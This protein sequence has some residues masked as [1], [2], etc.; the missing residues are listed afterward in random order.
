MIP[1]WLIIGSITFLVAILINR[2]S[3]SD[4]RWFMRLRRPQWL[5]F[6]WAIPFI[7]T[8][9]FIC[10]AYSAY[11]VWITNPG[12]PQ[13]WLLMA[14]YLFLEVLIMAYTPVMCKLRSLKVGTIIGGTGFFWGLMLACLIWPVSG[15][16]V[17][18]LLPYLLWSPIGTYVTWEMIALNPMDA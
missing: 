15:W 9:I 18:L 16:A 7:W 10:G 13:T 12:T 14:G 6:E 17:G 8:F 11:V 4:I 5:T 2:L 1:A 3:S